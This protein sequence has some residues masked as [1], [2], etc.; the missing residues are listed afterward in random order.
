MLFGTVTARF[1]LFFDTKIKNPGRSTIR[2]RRRKRAT[3]D[4]N[5]ESAEAE[6]SHSQHQHGR[7]QGKHARG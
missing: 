7:H 4:Q 3:T 2:D 1:P 6:A 5:A